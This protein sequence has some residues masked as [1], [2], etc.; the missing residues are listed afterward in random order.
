MPPDNGYSPRFIG[1]ANKLPNCFSNGT[2]WKESA[3][4]KIGIEIEHQFLLFIAHFSLKFCD[5]NVI[6]NM[7]MSILH[8]PTHFYVL[9]MTSSCSLLYTVLFATDFRTTNQPPPS[10]Q[11]VQVFLSETEFFDLNG[12]HTW[13]QGYPRVLNPL[14]PQVHSFPLDFDPSR[15]LWA[16][17]SK[18]TDNLVLTSPVR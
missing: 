17:N 15:T 7:L 3:V 5:W 8:H 14:R 4:Q 12:L 2:A 9:M 6:P 16:D 11:P 1:S 13:Y 10:S 18:I